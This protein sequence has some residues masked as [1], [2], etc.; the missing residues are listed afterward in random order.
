MAFTQRQ[1]KQ[2]ADAAQ[3]LKLYR[4]AELSAEESDKPLIEELY[5]DP[6]PSDGIFNAMMRPNTTFL[7]GR[8]GTG[9]S[10]IFQRSQHEIRKQ[11]HSVS[12]Y[13]D[14]KTIYESSEVDPALLQKVEA[15]QGALPAEGIRRIFLYEEFVKTV[16]VEIRTELKKQIEKS[17]LSRL[18]ERLLSSSDEVFEALDDLIESSRAS[19]FNDVTGIKIVG[20][21][22]G[23][24]SEAS[25]NA[26]VS[27]TISTDAVGMPKIAADGSVAAASASST[28]NENDFSQILLRSFNIKTIINELAEILKGFGIKRLYVF[29]DDFSELPEDAMSIFVDSILAPLNNWSQELIKFKIAAYPGRIYYG[30]IDKTKIDEAFLD[31]FK[32]YGSNDV[33]NMEEKAIDFTSRLIDTRLDHF[34]KARLSD[35]VE[36]SPDEVAK[37]LFF[38]TMG[39]PRNLGHILSNLYESH[40]VYGKF[41]GARAVR[42]AA[43]KYYEEKIEPFFG[44]QKFRHERFD[45]RLSIYS[46]KE[47]LELLVS[48]ARELRRYRESSLM[49]KIPGRPP[50]SHF[51]VVSELESVLSTLELNFFLTKYFEMK[52]RDGRKVSVFALNFG[53]CEKH[54]IEFGRPIGLRE[55]RLYFVER[56]FDSSHIIRSYLH[57][58]QEIKCADCE[59]IFGLDKLESLTLY[60]MRCPECGTGTCKVTNLS[61]KYEAILRDV[62]PELLLPTTELGILE[63]LYG[64]RRDLMAAEIAEDLDCSYQ[65]VGK[66]GKI[67]EQKGLVDRL[68]E[69]KRRKFRLT[70]LAMKEYFDGNESRR[71]DVGEG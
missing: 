38:A 6:L 12:A 33:S 53:L 9:K 11:S 59:A 22:E 23:N 57:A 58:N 32:L 36:A 41:I 55:F 45:E 10:T 37:L 21:K 3:S 44:I 30:Q 51:H 17:F 26:K 8:K 63:T 7:I 70:E 14:I 29:I 25:S 24:K 46:L 68:M 49:Q 40:I 67:M 56:I 1:R 18:K 47:L 42:D 64:E 52:D 54:S 69:Q 16:L 15:S 35:F 2:F 43:R 19:L 31:P 27:A 71:L 4:R 61:K 48:R 28:H 39:N 20:K 66:R 65:L 50:T 13:L 5:V 60:R 62:N 34:C